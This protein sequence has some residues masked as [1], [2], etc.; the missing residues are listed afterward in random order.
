ML[1]ACAKVRPPV[2]PAGVRLKLTNVWVDSLAGPTLG[3]E[4]KLS[5]VTRPAS[6]LLLV[7]AGNVKVGG[8]LT[9]TT[10]MVK[11]WAAQVW[12]AGG[13]ERALSVR[14]TVKVAVTLLLAAAW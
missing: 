4:A 14:V 6:S 7:L 1:G 9:A 10:V 12:R 8:S 3:F 2:V 5:A 11:V 13:G